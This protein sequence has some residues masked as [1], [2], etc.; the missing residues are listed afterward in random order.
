MRGHGVADFYFTPAPSQS[1]LINSNRFFLKLG[2]WVA[3]V[4]PSSPRF[5]AAQQTCD[6]VLGLPGAPP[7][8]TAAQLRGLIKAAACMRAHA[9]PGYPDPDVQDGHV[10]LK[11]LPTSIDT[12]SPQFQA[13]ET[14]CGE[15]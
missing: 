7:S 13:A 6:P 15:G 2:H 9:F 11:P 14:A 10:V 1:A 8:L 4:N 5:Q 3:W 12:S